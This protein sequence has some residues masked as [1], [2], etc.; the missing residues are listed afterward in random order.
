MNF[1]FGAAMMN[2]IIAW[3]FDCIAWIAH[4]VR[5]KSAEMEGLFGVID[6]GYLKLFDTEQLR[7]RSIIQNI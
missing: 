3:D 7:L 4:L 1:D 5:G 2:A 6:Q